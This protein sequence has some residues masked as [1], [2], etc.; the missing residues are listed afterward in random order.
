MQTSALPRRNIRVLRYESVSIEGT[1]VTI[2]TRLATS[3]VSSRSDVLSNAARL[4]VS[5]P[6]IREDDHIHALTRDAA[7]E[8]APLNHQRSWIKN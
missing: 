2:V 8:I 6:R 5:L 1:L 7:F 4:S 3:V